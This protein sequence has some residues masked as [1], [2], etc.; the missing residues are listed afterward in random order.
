[1]NKG[2][3]IAAVFVIFTFSI[4][5]FAQNPP[6]PMP[7]VSPTPTLPEIL[8]KADGQT[9]I[10]LETFKNLLSEETKTFEIYDKRGEVKKR[11]SVV[12]TFIV[13]PLSK[14]ENQI[15]EF[16]SVISVDGKALE[17]T[18]QRAQEFFE[19]IVKVESS[20]KEL[21][22]LQKESSRYDQ[23]IYISGLTLFQSIALSRDLRSL[24]EFNIESTEQIDG[25]EVFLVAYRQTKQ[26]PYITINSEAERDGGKLTQNF[27]VEIDKK[28]DLNERMRGKLWIDADTFQIR[29]E[30]REMTIQPEGFTSPLIV[31]E[32]NFEF[33]NSDFG[34]LTP[35][36]V[37]HLQNR[38]KIKDKTAIKEIKVVFDYEK[39]TKPDVEVQGEVK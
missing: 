36:K 26:S 21:E 20:K 2:K 28:V 31:V 35:K 38:V 1:M 34:I 11:R 27:D 8:D 39:F 19:Q 16:R 7:T 13:Y 22:R 5:I 15:T 3:L 10:Y 9:R 23:D 37:T 18:D 30:Q 14:D 33:Q 25:S 6:S 17:K 32:D 29:R 4:F 24:F 12:S